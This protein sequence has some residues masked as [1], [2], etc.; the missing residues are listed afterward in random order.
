M[1]QAGASLGRMT[2][3]KG[4]V[5]AGGGRGADADARRGRRDARFGR[6]AAHLR[7]AGRNAAAEECVAK[8]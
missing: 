7:A 1:R 5:V 4:H 2:T 6:E 8:L 3:G